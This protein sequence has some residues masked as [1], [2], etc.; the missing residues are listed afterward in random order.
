MG[1]GYISGL[2]G[3]AHQPQRLLAGSGD[4]VGQDAADVFE[5]FFCE[6]AN[7]FCNWKEAN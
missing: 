7:F 3:G 1:R 4:S 2:M 5:A 6:C